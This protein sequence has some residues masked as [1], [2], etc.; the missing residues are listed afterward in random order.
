MSGLT[1]HREILDKM[2]QTYITKKGDYGNSFSQTYQKFG[3][4]AALVRLWDKMN[5]LSNLYDKDP[6]VANESVL[7]TLYDL[8]NYAV[9]TIMEMEGDYD[10][11][12]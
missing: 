2:H 3:Q 12:D 5:R 7:D 1:R 9:L 6:Q 4:I 8:A 11:V 10:K